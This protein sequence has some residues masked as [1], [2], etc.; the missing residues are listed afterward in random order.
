M[1]KVLLNYADGRFHARP[2]TEAEAA[3]PAADAL[4]IHL[5]DGV[6]AAFQR[7][8]EQDAVWQ[9]LWRSLSSE[10]QLKTAL[11]N[12]AHE[13]LPHLSVGSGADDHHGGLPQLLG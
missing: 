2:V 10:Q 7:H 11:A 4:V 9:A 1:P 6:H 12:A 3:A 13:T 8:C 5:D